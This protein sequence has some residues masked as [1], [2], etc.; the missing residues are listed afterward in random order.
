LRL[1]GDALVQLG[2]EW[3]WINLRQQIAGVNVLTLD[4]GDFLDLAVN[5]SADRNSIERLDCAEAVEKDGDIFLAD[6][7]GNYW[8]RTC[9]P[10]P[11]LAR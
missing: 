1:F 11:A 6:R 9:R 10:A 4:E 8:Y 5:A 7:A 3:S 2:L